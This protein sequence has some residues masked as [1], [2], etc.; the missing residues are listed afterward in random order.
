MLKIG[1]LKELK[2]HEGRVLLTPP[3]VKVLTSHGLTVFVEN[4]AGEYCQF[5]DIDYER[6]GAIIVPT[7]EKV[8]QNADLVLQVQPPSPVQYEIYNESHTVL[9]FFNMQQSAERLKALV[10]SRATF[11]SAEMIQDGSGNYPILNGMGEIAGRMVIH[12]AAQLLTLVEGGKGKLLSGADI[13]KPAT[14]TV[15]G[16]GNAGRTAAKFARNLGAKVNLLVLKEKRFPE[17]R[18][19]YPKINV[20]MYSPEILDKLLPESDVFIVAVYS[21]RREFDIFIKK[22]TINRMEAGSVVID[23]SIEQIDVVESS[24]LTSHEK[25]TF[26][27]DHIVYYCVPNIAAIVPVTASKILTKRLWPYIKSLAINGLKTAIE[28][29]AGL[30]S[31]L[32]IYRSKITNRYLADY[33]GYDFYNIFELFELNL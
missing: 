8:M 6:C 11:L 27:L 24:H 19:Q 31:A 13:V 10:D 22:E 25:S 21:L 17:I 32:C 9:S 30:I 14:I 33:Y 18:N 26:I 23:L 7:M 3:G 12:K 2:Q 28:E 20:Q 5:S 29:E 15:L 1:L 16:A 4:D